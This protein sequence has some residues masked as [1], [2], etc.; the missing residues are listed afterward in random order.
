MDMNEYTLG[1]GKLI[2]T[3]LGRRP[4]HV[5]QAIKKLLSTPAIVSSD[6][7]LQRPRTLRRSPDS[8]G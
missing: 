6:Q 8:K 4:R 2:Y 1:E 3:P 7:A 5:Y